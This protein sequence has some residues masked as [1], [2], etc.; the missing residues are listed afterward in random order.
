LEAAISIESVGYGGAGVGRLPDGRVCFVH[1]TLPGERA[2]VRVVRER[3]NHA[4]AELLELLEASPRRV[5]P[6]CGVFGCCGGCAYQHA[7]YPLQLELKTAQVREVLRRL[8][9]FAD[10]RVEPAIASPLEYG[11]RNRISLHHS[12]RG[13]GFFQRG[14]HRVV[15]V[16]SCPLASEGVNAQIP[17]LDPRRAKPGTRITLRAENPPRGFSQVNPPAAELLADVVEEMAGTGG[18]LVDAYC[19]SGFFTRKLR[20]GFESAIGIEWSGAAVAAARELAAGNDTYLEGSVEG[21][22]ATTLQRS[23]PARTVLVADPPAEGL[24]PKVLAAILENP[25]VRIVYVSCDPATFARD[26]KRLAEKFAL[27]RVQPVDMFP[28]T[29]DIELAAL[30]VLKTP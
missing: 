5:K 15:P 2:R 22:L 14:S 21:L 19:G 11:Y 26:A 25:P 6:R 4:E 20:G 18:A 23:G 27:D 13:F 3:K 24:D 28:Q 1:G 9:G 29:A 12:P 17:S 8:G 7:A 30:L 16:G 10:A